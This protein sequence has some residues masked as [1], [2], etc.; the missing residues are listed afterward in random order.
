MRM[1]SA[2]RKSWSAKVVLKLEM[3]LAQCRAVGWKRTF[4]NFLRQ[5]RCDVDVPLMYEDPHNTLGH[6]AI[7]GARVSPRGVF[8]IV[9]AGNSSWRSL[10][11]FDASGVCWQ[12][13]MIFL[14]RRG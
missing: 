14:D 11:T 1:R 10:G 13:A 7:A 6:G 9:A 3:V 12:G 2:K 4:E 5:R 8:W